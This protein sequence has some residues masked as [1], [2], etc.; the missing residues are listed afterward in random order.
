MSALY[1]NLCGSTHLKA[2]FSLL[3]YFFLTPLPS[4]FSEPPLHV[5][6]P[7]SPEI[8]DKQNEQKTEKLKK[9]KGAKQKNSEEVG[10]GLHFFI[11]N[12]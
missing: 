10:R 6:A 4:F 3:N 2:S 12:F 1:L 11:L 5:S 8:D 7:M 9:K